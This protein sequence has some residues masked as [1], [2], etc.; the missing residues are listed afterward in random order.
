M[1][2]IGEAPL[3]YGSLLSQQVAPTMSRTLDRARS[4]A[5]KPY[6]DSKNAAAAHAN[7]LGEFYK[8]IGT[9][10][11]RPEVRRMQRLAGVNRKLPEVTVRRTRSHAVP[12]SVLAQ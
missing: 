5:R 8:K 4:S 2:F 12:L 6:R 9:N 1:I 11:K 10:P 7:L 3:C